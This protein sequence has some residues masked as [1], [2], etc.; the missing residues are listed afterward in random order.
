MRAAPGLIHEVDRRRPL[1]RHQPWTLDPPSPGLPVAGQRAPL[2]ETTCR[3]LACDPSDER[4][5]VGSLLTSLP[6]GPG[7]LARHPPLLLAAALLLLP[8]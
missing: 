1:A 2:A 3:C 8:C 5:K 7:A 4:E 6:R